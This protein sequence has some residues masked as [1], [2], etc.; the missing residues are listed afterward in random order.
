MLDEN[1]FDGIGDAYA[2]QLARLSFRS[3]TKHNQNR[4]LGGQPTMNGLE[5]GISVM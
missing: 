1:G 5:A 2:V 3:H 4:P